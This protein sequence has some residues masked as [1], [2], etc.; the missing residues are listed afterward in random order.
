MKIHIVI[1]FIYLGLSWYILRMKK[2]QE[3][4]VMVM[5][6]VFSSA[7]FDDFSPS[8]CWMVC[9]EFSTEFTLRKHQVLVC[10]SWLQKKQGRKNQKRCCIQY[11]Q[12]Y[13]TNSR[14]CHFS[15]EVK[16]IPI[17]P[18]PPP[19][20]RIDVYK[21]YLRPQTWPF[22]VSMLNFRGYILIIFQ[23]LPSLKLT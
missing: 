22:G 23:P 5:D 17:T 3:N 11:S 13:Y 21:M 4:V 18:P 7:R 14:V 2:I 16:I 9:I 1:P 15:L 20:F 6:I 10:M 12:C 8:T 19:K